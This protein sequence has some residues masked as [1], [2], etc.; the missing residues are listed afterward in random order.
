M[1]GTC[2]G[3]CQRHVGT[4]RSGQ[5]GVMWLYIQ[6]RCCRAGCG[7]FLLVQLIL[8]LDARCAVCRRTC[9]WQL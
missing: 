2:W 9:R 7:V 3:W 5:A 8:P 6:W 4:S 1:G